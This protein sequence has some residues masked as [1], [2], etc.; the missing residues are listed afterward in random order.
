MW[1][2]EGGS[3][4]PSESVCGHG[5]GSQRLALGARARRGPGT[6][7]ISTD[8]RYARISTSHAYTHDPYDHTHTVQHTSL[9]GGK[10]WFGPPSSGYGYE[11]KRPQ[12]HKVADTL[13]QFR[14]PG[15]LSLLANHTGG[16]SHSRLKKHTLKS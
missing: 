4:R 9:A 7:S 16:R 2:R 8:G 5:R 6:L 11:A 10:W 15:V 12:A 3:G 13:N 14:D 1:E